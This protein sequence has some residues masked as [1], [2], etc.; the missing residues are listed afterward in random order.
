MDQK[1]LSELKD[2]IKHHLENA[3]N[4]IESSRKTGLPESVRRT[5]AVEE[6][7]MAE[8]KMRELEHEVQPH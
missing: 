7:R 6:L 5:Q 3:E 1:E 8:V 2:E 4:Y